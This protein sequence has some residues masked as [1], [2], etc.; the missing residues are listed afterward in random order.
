MGQILEHLVMAEAGTNVIRVS[1]EKD[2]GSFSWDENTVIEFFLL[3]LS[4]MIYYQGCFER[5][6]R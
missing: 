5:L 3:T 1:C 6:L 2:I 4:F